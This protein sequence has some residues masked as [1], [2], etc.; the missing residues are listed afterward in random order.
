M[1]DE[2]QS[3]RVICEGGLYTN[4]NNLLL[5][6]KA[7]GAAT[8][9]INYEVSLAGG[10]RRLSGFEPLDSEYEIVDD[11]NAEGPILGAFIYETDVNTIEF[12]VARKQKVGNSYKW[13]KYLAGVGWVA[14]ATGLTLE[15]NDGANEVKRIRTAA[16]NFGDGNQVC[17]VDGINNATIFDGAVWSNI[18]PAGTGA[19]FANAGGAQALGAPALVAV[20]ENHL[21][22]AGDYGFQSI[23]SHSSPNAAYDFTVANG[24]GQIIAG[25]NVVQIKPFRSYNYVFGRNSIKRIE[26]DSGTAGFNIQDVT[27]NIGCVA[28][29][30][31]VEISG[32]LVFL[33]PDGIRPIAGTAKIGD[34]EI[35]SISRPIQ[36]LVNTVIDNEDLDDF[37]G[38]AIRKKSQVRFFY[39]NEDN[40][41]HNSYGIIGGLRLSDSSTTG[42]K[43]E[44]GQILGIRANV[45]VSGF[46]DNAEIVI[47]GDYNG[48]VYKQESSN[49]FN[50]EKIL[51]IYS[52]PY[53]DQGDTEIRKT[54]RTLNVFVK[55]EGSFALN[56]GTQYDWGDARILVPRNYANEIFG[57]PTIYDGLD[58]V[59]DDIEA[60]YGATNVPV[61]RQNI[62]G[63]GF[64]IRNTFTSNT[65][66]APH[67]IQGF[68]IEITPKGRK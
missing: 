23:I 21:F 14:Q 9:L 42:V 47:H 7:P 56:I 40:D 57:T 19:D 50:G 18:D 54:Y 10:Y 28:R 64:S 63:S 20:F 8:R 3:Q 26:V 24:A 62:E 37:I 33:S 30:S 27:T 15:F 29:D 32:D 16:F 11:T 43:W 65:T 52:P 34:I 51:S 49:A 22:L 38:V 12:Y 35:E 2:I 48:G 31:V 17:I 53:L 46:F 13:Y 6:D 36:A 39:S 5:S 61:I 41:V 67:S 1:S 4:D 44:W 55:A 66:D 60:V 68:V 45:A 58:V 59:Y 25:F